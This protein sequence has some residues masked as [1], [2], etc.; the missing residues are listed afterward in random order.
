MK[1]LL[2]ICMIVSLL[3]SCK[4]DE[5]P[6]QNIA[7]AIRKCSGCERTV[8]PFVNMDSINIKKP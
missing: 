3:T 2:Y 5:L 6:A 7:D 8:R 4:K 1:K